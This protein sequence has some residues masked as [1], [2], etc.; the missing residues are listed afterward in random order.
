MDTGLVII[1]FVV[2]ALLLIT[3]G[4]AKLTAAYKSRI[5]TIQQ[6]GLSGINYFEDFINGIQGT[7]YNQYV[8]GGGNVIQG[9]TGG[10]AVPRP[11]LVRLHTSS[12]ADVAAITAYAP[13]V[14][15][16]ACLNS[17]FG[18]V[19]TL[20]TDLTFNGTSTGT[21]KFTWGLCDDIT[22]NKGTYFK[23][24]FS[25]SNNWI[26]V[27]NANGST[28]SQQ[29]TTIPVD[30]VTNDF[31]RLK[32][33][34]TSTTSLFYINAVLVATIQATQPADYYIVPIAYLLAGSA[35]N[36]PS[37]WI[38]YHWLVVQLASPRLAP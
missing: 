29:I 1:L 7:A 9:G 26:C 6:T 23:V 17:T 22:L 19:I 2:V 24:D 36:I 4:I 13:L 5:N 11:T 20:G 25:V 37:V 10:S 15:N 34:H 33:V 38:D 27:R 31:T 3:Y 32:V 18:V 14:G 8:L 12:S 35:V 30:L 16:D 21:D 28:P